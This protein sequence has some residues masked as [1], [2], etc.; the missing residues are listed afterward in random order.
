MDQKNE[1]VLR[2]KEDE[3]FKILITKLAE[4]ELNGAKF[5]SVIN[6]LVEENNTLKETILELKTEKK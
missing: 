1:T 6:G 5:E 3:V 2:F 4:S